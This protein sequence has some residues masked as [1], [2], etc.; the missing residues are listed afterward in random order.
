MDRGIFQGFQGFGSL[1]GSFTEDACLEEEKHCFELASK[2]SALNFPFLPFVVVSFT[3]FF[4]H[5][6]VYWY[7]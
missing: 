2:S 6:I 3:Y 7:D 1:I 5:E 4:F